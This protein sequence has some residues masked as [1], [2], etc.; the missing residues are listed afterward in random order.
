MSNTLWPSPGSSLHG[1]IQVRILGWGIA[2][3]FSRGSSWPKDWT[4][5]S[6]I[7]GRFFT[8]WATREAPVIKS[9]CDLT[10]KVL[11]NNVKWREGAIWFGMKNNLLWRNGLFS[12]MWL[13]KGWALSPIEIN[14]K[15]QINTC[16]MILSHEK[17]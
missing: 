13:Y 3:P 14:Y 5:V 8:V 7:V 4:W 2:V 6:C 1:I 10:R 17:Q 9:F 12:R 15:H 11:R 16:G